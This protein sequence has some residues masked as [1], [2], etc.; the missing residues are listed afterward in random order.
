MQLSNQPHPA[1]NHTANASTLLGLSYL[2]SFAALPGLHNTLPDE[3]QL[4]NMAPDDLR[5]IIANLKT[6]MAKAE[7]QSVCEPGS[8]GLDSSVSKATTG[9]LSTKN[10][11]GYKADTAS[12]D[13]TSAADSLS[14]LEYELASVR[15]ERT[16]LRRQLDTVLYGP[17]SDRDVRIIPVLKQQL[18]DA[19]VRSTNGNQA[20]QNQSTQGGNATTLDND[21]AAL[22]S[23]L[24][25]LETSNFVLKQQ[26]EEQLKQKEQNGGS[27]GS[28]GDLVRQMALEIERLNWQLQ[29]QQQQQANEASS[30]DESQPTNRRTQNS[31]NLVVSVAERIFHM[32]WIRKVIDK[33]DTMFDV[34]T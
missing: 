15:K 3:S 31:G 5:A 19:Q 17:T 13:H 34:M 1:A 10:S 22:R 20:R 32:F 24:A 12:G 18:A 14:R 26:L 9:V 33:M 11:D 2:P 21:T 8:H 4:Q 28:G 30:S 6:E 16:D 29:I 23:R 7:E 27:G 25:S